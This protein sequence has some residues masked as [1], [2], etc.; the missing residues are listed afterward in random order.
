[1]TASLNFDCFEGLGGRTEPP[2]STWMPT[3]PKG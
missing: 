3:T 1:M 2:V